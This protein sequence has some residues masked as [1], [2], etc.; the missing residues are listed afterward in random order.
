MAHRPAAVWRS[1]RSWRSWRS[2]HCT[3][4]GVT[5]RRDDSVVDVIAGHRVHDP[6]RWLE[7]ETDPDVVAWLAAQDD[8]CRRGLAALPERDAIAARIREL[9]YFD[10]VG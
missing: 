3:V 9:F 5:S 2:G 6:Y 10:A 7:V 4:T 8:V 1:G